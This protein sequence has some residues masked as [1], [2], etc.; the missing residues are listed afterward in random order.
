LKIA[1]RAL[2]PDKP[3]STRTKYKRQA[4]VNGMAKTIGF[5]FISD[6]LRK[7]RD[8]YKPITA[9]RKAKP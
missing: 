1:L 7:W 3:I 9:R 2:S 8:F 5:G 4:R 6:W